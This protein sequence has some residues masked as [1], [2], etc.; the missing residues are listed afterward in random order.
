MRLKQVLIAVVAF[1]TLIAA[2]CAPKSK[3]ENVAKVNRIYNR[4][5]QGNFGVTRRGLNFL[6]Y[7]KGQFV[8]AVTTDKGRRS[9]ST[10][11]V[12]D[13][14]GDLVVLMVES[15]TPDSEGVSLM[16][17]RGLEKARRTQDPSSVDIVKVRVKNDKGEVHEMDG[18]QLKMMTAL[19]RKQLPIV[20]FSG[21]PVYTGTIA[22]P[23]GRF[24][25]TMKVRSKV[26]L[27]GKTYTADGFYHTAVPINAM[28]KSVSGDS[29]T[30]LID[31]G[32]N[33]TV[34]MF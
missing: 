26:R 3:P 6:P 32:Y 22:V 19:Y 13:K 15:V 30:E 5:R 28:V 9:A 18:F 27:L 1:S 31:F 34:E 25:S 10:I 7:Q 12:A 17:L 20:T 29:V 33:K 23:A 4:A 14:Q 11:T 24:A 8:T 16:F 21:T 2:G